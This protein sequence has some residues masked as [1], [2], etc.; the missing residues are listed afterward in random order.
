[1][2]QRLRLTFA[3]GGP[4]RYVSHLDTMRTWERTIRRAR[5]P[6][7]YTQGFSPHPR[8]ALAAPLPVG[9]EGDRELM[10]LWLDEPTAP[11]DAARALNAAAP[12]GLEVVSIEEVG[13]RLPS[14]QSQLASARYR[15][16]LDTSQLISDGPELVRRLDAL[17][18]LDALDWEE[19]RGDKVRRYDLRAT[20]IDLALDEDGATLRMH[21]SLEEGRTG[22]P[23]QVLRALELDTGVPHI[24]RTDVAL[25]PA[26]TD[27]ATTERAA[28]G[29]SA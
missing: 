12:P 21:L 11:A 2:T 10:D 22:R 6:L 26:D 3:I 27:P 16:Q 15:V 23:A 19:Q 13:D 17:L 29:Q 7:A 18:A 20:I 25:R 28:A 5:L 4:M 9:I 1:M 14:L 24:V 8:I